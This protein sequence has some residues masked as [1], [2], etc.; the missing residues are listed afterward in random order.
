M[1]KYTRKHNLKKNQFG[2]GL[3]ADRSQGL[4]RPIKNV[5]LLKITKEYIIVD[6]CE[7]FSQELFT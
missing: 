6:Y 7:V 5:L 2:K 3:V 4:L 1:Q